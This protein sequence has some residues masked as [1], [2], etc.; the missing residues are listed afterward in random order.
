MTNTASRR[1]YSDPVAIGL[2]LGSLLFLTILVVGRGL[3]ASGAFAAGAAAAV[4]AVAP[5]VIASNGYLA[6]R[7]PIFG[8]GLMGE[9]IVLELLGVGLGA[10]WSARRSG[11][12]ALSVESPSGES[13][14]NRIAKAALGGALMGAGARFAHG[15]TSGLALTGGALLS[16]G[17]W[18]FIPIAFGVAILVAAL[19][20]RSA[21]GA[22]A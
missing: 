16:T 10:W 11:R 19:L 18:L 6:E 2:L 15:C 4:D 8:G 20:R 9:W 5:G 7:V 13:S 22:M 14:S 1:G 12:L 3:G 17:A 21:S